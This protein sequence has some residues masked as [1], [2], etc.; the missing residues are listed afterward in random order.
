MFD[1]LGLARDVLVIA[2]MLFVR[3]AVPIWLTWMLGK[4]LQKLLRE[5]ET[6]PAE[7]DTV[8]GMCA[9]AQQPDVPCWLALQIS[10]HG[11]KPACYTCPLFTN[12]GRRL[13][14]APAVVRKTEKH[15][16]EE[17]RR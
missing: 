6:K 4:W 7:L 14:Q 1:W 3:I 2:Y 8:R 15:R 17:A 13:Q 16:S 11:L 12:V 5:P 10:G 9:E